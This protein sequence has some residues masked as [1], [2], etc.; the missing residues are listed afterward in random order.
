VSYDLDDRLD[1]IVAD[2]EPPATRPDLAPHP[3]DAAELFCPRC[4]DRLTFESRDEYVPAL[5]RTVV[6]VDGGGYCEGCAQD[7]A[8]DRLRAERPWLYV[9]LATDRA[10]H[11]YHR[12]RVR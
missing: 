8:L 7:D 1:V 11:A 12:E 5:R 10:W 3:D 2:R 6:I 9:G 4:G